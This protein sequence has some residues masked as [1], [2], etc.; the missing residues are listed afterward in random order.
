MDKLK[1]LKIINDKKI[2]DNKNLKFCGIVNGKLGVY[3]ELFIRIII[4]LNNKSHIE[5]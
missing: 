2:N 4:N 1:I 5:I 3:K